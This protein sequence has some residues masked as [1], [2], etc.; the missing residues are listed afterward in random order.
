MTLISQFAG[1]AG[2]QQ[3]RLTKAVQVLT[4]RRTGPLSITLAGLAAGLPELVGAEITNPSRR[5]A[6]GGSDL[7]LG[8]IGFFGQYLRG[9][10]VETFRE[11]KYT[12]EVNYW[13][14]QSSPIEL[15][16]EDQFFVTIQP[17]AASTYEV[18]APEQVLIP[19]ESSKF[20]NQETERIL[21]SDREKVLYTSDH[22][23]LLIPRTADIERV[24]ITIALP[25]MA[26]K[27]LPLTIAELLTQAQRANPFV[28]A[29]QIGEGTKFAFTQDA[30][31][32]CLSLNYTPQVEIRTKL[33]AV[34]DYMLVKVVDRN[35]LG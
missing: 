27:E 9:P 12:A 4:I 33:G 24:N 8:M 28:S 21:A 7:P 17:H 6:D 16:S 10:I 19:G 32:I 2:K 34:V 26:P 1:S 15:T 11:G 23:A 18:Y 29:A 20:Y 5:R 30:D 13:L 25:G 3:I 22:C 35:S 14:N 31:Y